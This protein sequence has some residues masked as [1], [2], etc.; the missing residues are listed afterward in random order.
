MKK[1]ISLTIDYE[2]YEILKES[3]K[4]Q[5]RSVSN[6]I[7]QLIKTKIKVKEKKDE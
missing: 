2:T 6:F 7:D 3:A 4:Q 5:N 1:R